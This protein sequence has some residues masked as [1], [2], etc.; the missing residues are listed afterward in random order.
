MGVSSKGEKIIFKVHLDD[1]DI[2]NLAE[3]TGA[4]DIILFHSDAV[5]TKHIKSILQQRGINAETLQ[6]PSMLEVK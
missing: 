5:H 6:Y 2:C 1:N 4:K 3:E